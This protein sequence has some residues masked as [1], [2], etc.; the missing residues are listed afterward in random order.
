MMNRSWNQRRLDERLAADEE[1]VLEVQKRGGESLEE[2]SSNDE[3]SFLLFSVF[4]GRRTG[5]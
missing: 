3:V 4:R 2:L 1:A 5:T